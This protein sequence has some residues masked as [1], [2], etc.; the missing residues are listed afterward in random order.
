MK[1][2]NWTPMIR[3]ADMAYPV[4]LSDFLA[5]NPNISIGSFVYEENMAEFGYYPVHDV[6][7]P[8]GDVVTEGAPIQDENGTWFKTWNVR[9]FT[10]E[11]IAQNL[12]F[13][14]QAAVAQAKYVLHN[15]LLNGLQVGNDLFAVGG[16]DMLFLHGTRVAALNADP[17]ETFF[18]VKS[19]SSVMQ[20]PAEDAVNKATEIITAHSAIYQRMLAYLDTVSKAQTKSEVPPFPTTFIE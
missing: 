14:K 15:D 1:I 18:I 6:E 17:S 12:A 19:D 20:L 11:E 3:T 8:T 13:D 7:V 10:P 9:E 16:A 2:E 4:Y 5:A